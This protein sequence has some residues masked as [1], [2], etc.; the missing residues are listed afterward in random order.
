MVTYEAPLVIFSVA[1]AIVASYT[2]LDLTRRVR[3]T[4]G[5]L[6]HF[7]LVG[8]AISLGIGIWSMHCVTMLA[9]YSPIPVSSAPLTRL[10][11]NAITGTH[12]TTIAAVSFRPVNLNSLAL[13][14][15]QPQRLHSTNIDCL[16]VAIG[17][18]TLL[19]LILTL[20][21][22]LIDQQLRAE[23]A[24]GA[25]A[26]RQSEERY[27]IISELT[28][29]FTYA[30][31]VSSNGEWCVEWVT[32]AFS[33]ITGYTLADVKGP[34]GWINII[35]PDD[36]PLVEQYY[37]ALLLG[38]ASESEFRIMT[39]DGTVRWVRSHARPQFDEAQQNIV[40]MLGAAK[41]ITEHRCTQEALYRVLKEQETIMETITDI[42]YVLTLNGDLLK[43]NR[44]LEAVTG[45]SPEELRGRSALVFFPELE[46]PT[47]TQAIKWVIETGNAQVEG[48]LIGK[49]GVLLP[50]DWNGVTLKDEAGNI[51]GI[52]GIGR[53]IAERKQAEATLAE[54]EGKFR[55]LIQNSSDIITILEP[56]GTIRYISPSAERILGYKP[57]ELVG[58]NAFDFT[59]PADLSTVH[60]RF[61]ELVQYPATTL[62]VEFRF[63]CK[64]NSWCFIESTGSN[65]LTESAVTGI[66]VNSRDVT[67]RKQ[68]EKKLQ[69]LNADLE[70]QVQERTAQVQQALDFEATLK[71]ITDKVRDSL[72][73]N[74][75][76][77]AAVQELAIGLGV[78]CC[79]TALYNL[80]Q[81]T[82]TIR[83]QYFFTAPNKLSSAS[84]WMD[85]EPPSSVGRVIQMTDFWQGY[86][87]LLQGRYFQFCELTPELVWSPMAVLAC[88][89]IDEQGVL[90]D[91]WVLNQQ[92]YA[93]NEQEVRLVQ[94]V[95]NHCAIAIH[96]ARLFQAT[97]AQVRELEHLNR[98]K[99]D[100]LSTVSH[101]LRSPV[102]NMKMAIQMLQIT[103][104]SDRQQRYLKILQDECD[105]E[106]VL[107]NNLLDLQRL[108]AA[109]Y[110]NYM[111]EAVDLQI[112][113][114]N[115]IEP[116]R[117]R[118]QERQQ[119]LHIDLPSSLP[120]VVLESTS[121]GRIL[122]EL[123]NNACKY[124][125]AGGKISLSVRYDSST[126]TR[127]RH[128]S[129]ARLSSK[130]DSRI[131]PPV[132]VFTIQN[133]AEISQVELPRIFEKFYRV[134]D[135]DRWKQGGTGLGLALIRKLV[136]QLQG[137]IQ[138]DSREG[139]T[140]F[141]VQ[142]P[143]QSGA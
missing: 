66:V 18:A 12:A 41:D 15:P 107:V 138:V 131:T 3:L 67:E 54:S 19:I 64:D 93:F 94:Q 103:K 76:L 62:C 99:D 112:W 117:S 108:E 100:F 39:K 73:E 140:T 28:S 5:R 82:S 46:R 125:P 95:A 75:I 96:Q 50:Y 126:S 142:L 36:L 113:L 42:F 49:D 34:N 101:E 45:L 110:S 29:D 120:P 8:S 130:D 44:K 11:G 116:F 31:S 58:R 74:Q 10:M 80:D 109:S 133:E 139:W 134:P 13:G 141:T 59:H 33:Q 97:Q 63:R 53:D 22:S 98:L 20:L 4:L 79:D 83:Y 9:G 143:T 17:V 89:I 88:P 38:Q 135:T 104:D 127:S 60:S 68:A 27:R 61:S 48:H 92:D 26:L 118:T 122:A 21:T 14:L 40:R 37:Q 136:E 106:A 128:S 35:Y 114:P 32:E 90:G 121:L 111:V 24:R 43:W 2:A 47:I 23:T 105:R 6:R 81:A 72:D 137:S 30:T 123:L 57:E 119:M 115:I 129:I 51:I 77:Q 124:T 16:A 69:Q 1:I 78:I 7:W 70:Y 132:I 87:Q 84:C 91:L 52:T 56:N 86:R 71:R 102:S 25:E 85:S 65:L 55:S